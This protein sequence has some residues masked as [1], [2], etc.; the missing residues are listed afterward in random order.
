M[1]LLQICQQLR[2]RIILRTTIYDLPRRAA[3]IRI[4]DLGERVL[5]SSQSG[6][7]VVIDATSVAIARSSRWC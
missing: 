4:D 3:A 7:E 1:S 2:I 5:P 6:E